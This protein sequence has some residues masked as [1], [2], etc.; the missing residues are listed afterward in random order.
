M[1][2]NIPPTMFLFYL[3][4][5]FGKHDGKHEIGEGKIKM[6]NISPKNYLKQPQVLYLVEEQ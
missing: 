4:T 3:E 6:D 5:H 2:E 1:L